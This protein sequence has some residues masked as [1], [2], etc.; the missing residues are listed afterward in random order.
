M[1]FSGIKEKLSESRER[2]SVSAIIPVEKL[3]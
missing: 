3:Q 2:K 1:F